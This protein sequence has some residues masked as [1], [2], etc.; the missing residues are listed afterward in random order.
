MAR[1]VGLRMLDLLRGDAVEC[2]DDALA[3]RPEQP[4]DDE[5]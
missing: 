3:D 2:G 1:E 4:V 5:Q